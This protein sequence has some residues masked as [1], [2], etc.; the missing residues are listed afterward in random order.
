M[1]MF[2]MSFFNVL[3]FLMYCYFASFI[4]L[5]KKK[6]NFKKF[7]LALILFL[8]GYYCVLCLLDSIYAIFFSGLCAF[9]FI[10]VI[11]LENIYMSLFISTV[12]HT[13]KI[14]TK[15][16][17]LI[18]ITKDE[19][20]VLINTYKTLTEQGVYINLITLSISMVIIFMLKG[21]LQ[22]FIKYI[23]RLKN[24]NLVLLIMIYFNFILI[25]IYQP[26]NNLLSL[27]TITDFMMIFVV[28]AMG[29]FSVSSEMKMES[30]KNYYKEI[31]E[32]SKING[33][34]ITNYKMQVHENKN[35]LLMIRS[36]LDGPKQSVKRYVDNLLEE[37]ADTEKNSN[38]WLGELRYICWDGIRNFINYKL[39]K[40][41][42]LGAEI[43][44]FVSSELEKLD[45]ELMNE[46]EYN[47]LVTILGVVLDN[48]IESI[49]ETENKL[50]SVNI[51]IEDNKIHY[52]FVNTY[53]GKIDLSRLNEIGYTTKGEQHGVGLP[54]VAKIV[55]SNSRFECNPKIVDD[56]F[57]QHLKV[58]I[59]D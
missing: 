57:V 38:Y 11:F 31:F 21:P 25:L 14:V 47:Q 51:Y 49:S 27:R 17:Y 45:R 4:L 36:M 12:I 26:P 29:I 44:V 7:P 9:L 34:L 41:S 10:K 2:I 15:M 8:M 33:K 59:Y 30:L 19:T 58:K 5:Q 13:I 24:R 54:L 52:E 53:A 50:I 3:T 32:C 46:N 18:F 39:T 40:L 42:D 48:M 35:R 6:L 56:F 28:T 23:S 1:R 16:L 20:L 22:K 43:E 37:I 55:K